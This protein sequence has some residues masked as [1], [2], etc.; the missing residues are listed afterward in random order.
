MQEVMLKRGTLE[1]WSLHDE[2]LA[3]EEQLASVSEQV[4]ETRRMW[5]S[6][7]ARVQELVW[8]AESPLP[9]GMGGSF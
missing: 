7:A 8:G 9:S 6:E 4:Q 3:T 5:L 2:L 1:W